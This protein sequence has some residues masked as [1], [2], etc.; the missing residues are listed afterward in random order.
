MQRKYNKVGRPPRHIKA[1]RELVINLS[2]DVMLR[3]LE[4]PKGSMQHKVEIAKS[5]CVKNMPTQLEGGQ[6]I[7][8]NVVNAESNKDNPNPNRRIQIQ[9]A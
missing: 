2:W 6:S 9:R 7:V 5:I 1:Q 8:I 3:Y 4:D